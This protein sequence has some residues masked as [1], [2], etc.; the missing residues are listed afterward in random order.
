M[1]YM[2]AIWI[3]AIHAL[4]KSHTEA[5][6]GFGWLKNSG[7][8]QLEDQVFRLSIN[9][10]KDLYSTITQDLGLYHAEAFA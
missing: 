5:Y 3:A 2:D 4:D 6:I 9:S 8:Q 10:H 7:P 1:I